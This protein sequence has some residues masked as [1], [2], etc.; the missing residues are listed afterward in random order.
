MSNVNWTIGLVLFMYTNDSQGQKNRAKKKFRLQNE[1]EIKHNSNKILT[2]L[3]KNTWA[4][5][6]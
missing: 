6:A 3:I 2:Y 1:K 4:G 5:L